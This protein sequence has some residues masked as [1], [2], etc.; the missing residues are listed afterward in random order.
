M[1]GWCLTWERNL[2]YLSHPRVGV[3]HWDSSRRCEDACPWEDIMSLAQLP[4]LARSG[5]KAETRESLEKQFG[6]SGRCLQTSWCSGLFSFLPKFQLGTFKLLPGSEELKPEFPSPPNRCSSVL[7]L[8]INAKRE[9]TLQGK[10]GSCREGARTCA[11]GHSLG[12]EALYSSLASPVFVRSDSKVGKG[13]LYTEG[14]NGTHGLWRE[15]WRRAQAIACI[16]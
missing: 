2:Q 3:H 6:V 15:T 13:E 8:L 11:L 9:E 5:C 1:R 7:N 16:C 10:L 14:V 4:V 12:T